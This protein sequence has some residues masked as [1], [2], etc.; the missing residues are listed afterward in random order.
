M[1]V[2]L[3]NLGTVYYFVA[4][5]SQNLISSSSQSLSG[6]ALGKLPQY[7]HQQIENNRLRQCLNILAPYPVLNN[8]SL[9]GSHFTIKYTTISITVYSNHVL[10]QIHIFIGKSMSRS[11]IISLV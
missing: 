5:T 6:D 9:I 1:L 3:C 4:Q 2:P 8:C 11:L 7:T 10:L